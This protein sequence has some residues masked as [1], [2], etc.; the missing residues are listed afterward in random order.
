MWTRPVL[1][2]SERLSPAHTPT[3][4]RRLPQERLHQLMALAQA[5][6]TSTL[7]PATRAV[8]RDLARRLVRGRQGREGSRRMGTHALAWLRA[9]SGEGAGG[10]E[11]GCSRVLESACAGIGRLN[12][13]F[14][15]AHGRRIALAAAQVRELAHMVLEMEHQLILIAAGGMGEGSGDSMDSGEDDAC[16]CPRAPP[17]QRRCRRVNQQQQQRICLL[18]C[19]LN[20][21]L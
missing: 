15:G 10:S 1:L 16:S 17:D 9:S 4:A 21:T 7:L 13:C 19:L 14:I 12:C 6:Q 18:P 5:A 20:T 11:P 8:L 2:L 3:H